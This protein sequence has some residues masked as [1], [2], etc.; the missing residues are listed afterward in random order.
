MNQLYSG[1]IIFSLLLFISIASAIGQSQVSVKGNISEE[2]SGQPLIGV[3]ITIKDKLIGTISDVNGNF[4]LITKTPPPFTL[5]FSI[6]GYETQEKEVSVNPETSLRYDIEL[7]EKTIFGQEVVV[8][9][10]RVEESILSSP[11]SIEKMGIIDIQ[12]SSSSNFYDGL[13]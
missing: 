12:Q 6:V 10:S 1:C 8:S 5:V 9:A 13:Y 3:N 2:S 4:T 11:V 7:K